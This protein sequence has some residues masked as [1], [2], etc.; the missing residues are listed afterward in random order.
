MARNGFLRSMRQCNA[1]RG[2]AA[3]FYW[4]AMLFPKTIQM[5][6][7]DRHVFANAAE[8]GELAVSGGFVF[9]DMAPAA[10]SGKTRQAFANGF[11]GTGSFGWSSFVAVAEITTQEYDTVIAALAAHFVA[12]YGAPDLDA[13]MPA[14]RAEAQFAADLCA[15]PINTLLCVARESAPDGIREQFRCVEP[16]RNTQHA[17]VWTIESGQDDD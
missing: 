11:L 16:W 14:A 17:P 2:R 5:D 6:A 10:L 4:R 1:V 9:A 7:S 13:A 12:H 15:Y 8:P 3:T